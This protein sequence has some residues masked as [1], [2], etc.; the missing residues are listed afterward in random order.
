MAVYYVEYGT[1][2]TLHGYQLVDRSTGQYKTTPT[3]ATGDFKVEK[4]GGRQRISPRCRPCPRPG[5]VP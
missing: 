5:A 4:D 2:W 3:L 1:A